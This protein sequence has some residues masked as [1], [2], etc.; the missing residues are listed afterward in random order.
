MTTLSRSAL[1]PYAPY[2]MYALVNEI[3]RYPEFLP[4]CKSTQIHERS[5]DEVRATIDMAKGSMRKSFTTRN[6]MQNDKMIEIS[7]VDGPFSHLHGFWRFDLLGEKACKVSL[8][9]EFDFSNRLLGL[10]VGPMFGQIVASLVDAFV[11]RARD[12][13]GPR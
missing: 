6:N 2:E 4:W 5:E 9:I 10:A 12:V 8:D 3:E 1:V 11:K 7:L 13:Y